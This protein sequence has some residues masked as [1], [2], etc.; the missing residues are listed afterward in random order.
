MIALRLDALGHAISAL[1]FYE[2]LHGGSEALVRKGEE[3]GMI[4]S[5]YAMIIRK[6]LDGAYSVLNEFFGCDCSFLYEL[7]TAYRDIKR[8]QDHSMA[9]EEIEKNIE[10]VRS[11]SFDKLPA[12]DLV[13][14]M[15]TDHE[16]RRMR[17]AIIEYQ[18]RE[19][20]EAPVKAK[21]QTGAPNPDQD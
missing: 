10:L 13:D 21:D 2:N 16:L 12:E 6:S 9:L 1:G 4:V 15:E 18:K 3:L 5:D 17:A 20:K 8:M 11:T 7:R 14:I 19:K